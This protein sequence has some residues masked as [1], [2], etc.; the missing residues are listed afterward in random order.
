MSASVSVTPRVNQITAKCDQLIES[1][2]KVKE[3]DS[4]EVHVMLL[5]SLRELEELLPCGALD[6]VDLME[7]HISELE[8]FANEQFGVLLMELVM[9]F[10]K[11]QG[12][13]PMEILSL[14]GITDNVS[15]IVEAMNVLSDVKLI[16]KSP[17]LTVQLLEHLLQ[18]DSYLTF[19]ITRMSHTQLNEPTV[20]RT[21]QFIQ[22]LISLPDKIANQLKSDFPG[23]FELRK[24]SAILMLNALKSFHIACQI[25]KMEQSN[26]YS[27]KFLSK[28][29][30]RI[31]VHFKGDKTVLLSSL[32][33][34]SSMAGQELYRQNLRE[35]M[36]GLQRPAVEIA[37]QL[38]F[39]NESKTKLVW[40][41]GDI[42][43]TSS[44]WKFVLLKKIP[45]LSFSFDDQ[46]VENLV[47]FLASE[48]EG[49]LE[50]LLIDLLMVWS[51]KSHVIDA[52]FDQHF[53]VTKLIVLMTKYL[54]NP[55]DKAEKIKQLLFKGTQ[56]HL[57]S[58]D[59]KIQVLGMITAEVVLGVLDKDVK[60]E[61]KLKFDFSDVSKEVAQEVVEVI[62]RLPERMSLEC[63]AVTDDEVTKMVQKLISIVEQTEEPETIKKPKV[64]V[65]IKIQ[66][67]PKVAQQTP[68]PLDSDDDDDL[69]SY[70][71]PDDLPRHDQK[72]P[73]YLLD[74]IQA[75]TSKE[76]RDD[77][78]VFEL[79]MT[80]AERIIN[81]QLPSHHADI[82]VDLLMIFLKLNKAT[83]FENFDE[84]RMKLLVLITS[85][86][87]KECAQALCKEFNTESQEYSII[88]R[89][90][91]LETLAEVAKKLS[92]L[93]MPQQEELQGSS[94][95]PVIAPPNKL[96][97]RLNEELESRNKKDAQK[98]IR[99][100]LLAKTRRIATRTKSPHEN[101]GVNR[102]ADV[103]GWFFFP[104][105]HG[106]GRKQMVFKTGTHLQ[107]EMF[108][109]LLVKFINTI[110]VMMLCA[111]NSIIAPKMGKEIVSL[112]VFLRYHEESK[113]R[114]A[115]LHMVATIVLAV[116]Q[117]ILINEFSR[118][119][120]EFINHLGM[121]VKSS[122]VNY[123]PD[124]ECREFAKQLMGM[125]QQALCAHERI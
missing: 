99:Q 111:E 45:L 98:I 12:Q 54:S 36:N 100:R 123:E 39:G 80:S 115:V 74:I 38:A 122:V 29:I 94:A 69:Q 65:E 11:S 97:I 53:Y 31:F 92:K 18:D 47:F 6:Q 20:L 113:I 14:V 85:I 81:Q 35:M 101:S 66:D 52:P 13:L 28:L 70:D 61:D 2:E 51:T 21:D 102:F 24:F 90:S 67:P 68:Q 121:I 17:H 103:A 120:S 9:K 83:Y 114:L 78:E 55:K 87:P 62:R 107:D 34:M 5:L 88:Q 112:S 119:I 46:T 10:G 84:L 7:H 41:F 4:S 3:I 57:G 75:F 25:N 118:E 63:Y 60:D 27:M 72:R 26:V 22:Q 124:Q 82:A 108:N 104:L 105:V 43:K 58:S 59:K 32:R 86:H 37:A 116:P 56:V 42:W 109:V 96:L 110:A 16:D 19:A 91:M 30:S 64:V 15:F 77:A 93:E 49:M 117:K 48:D 125:F 89:I 8:S 73:R 106:F 44:D 79:T 50:Q 95:S 33:L 71:D 76:S 40:M 1:L 23:V